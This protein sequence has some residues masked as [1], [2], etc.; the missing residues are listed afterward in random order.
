L[1]GIGEA[2]GIVLRHNTVPR[3][4]LLRTAERIHL[5]ELRDVRLEDLQAVTRTA[6]A[7]TASKG[8]LSV[9][10]SGRITPLPTKR[11]CG[12]GVGELQ[13]EFAHADEFLARAAANGG[14]ESERDFT[15]SRHR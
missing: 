6:R 13:F 7:L 1:P 2:S 11:T 14:L 12:F 5:Q 8:T 15:E 10:A 9:V 3:G 4:Q